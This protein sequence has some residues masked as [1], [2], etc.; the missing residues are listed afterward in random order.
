MT[1]NPSVQLSPGHSTNQLKNQNEIK[2]AD[3]IVL[4]GTYNETAIAT[5]LI[6]KWIAAQSKMCGKNYFGCEDPI[7]QIFLS[8]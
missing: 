4:I 2:T 6:V 3:C 8:V 1:K 7:S 5:N